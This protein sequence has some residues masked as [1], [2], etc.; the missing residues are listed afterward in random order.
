M[1][2]PIIIVLNAKENSPIKL[3]LCLVMIVTKGIIMDGV[4]LSEIKGLM[5]DK[6]ICD[7]NCI[8]AFHRKDCC[9]EE[10]NQALTDQGSRSIGLDREKLKQL[11]NKLPIVYTMAGINSEP[12]KTILDAIIAN[13][14]EIIVFKGTK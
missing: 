2:N 4:K 5:V 12:V 1:E 10:I 8:D 3:K 6:K 11:L 9:H 13:A 14:K 7:R